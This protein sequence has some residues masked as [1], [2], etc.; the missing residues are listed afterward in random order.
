MGFRGDA[1]GVGMGEAVQR[2]AKGLVRRQVRLAGGAVAVDFG[3]NGLFRTPGCPDGGV[4]SAPSARLV[5]AFLNAMVAAS[6]SVA[7]AVRHRHFVCLRQRWVG[8]NRPR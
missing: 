4:F 6:P 1:S 5:R 7:P 3:I 8:V 2:L